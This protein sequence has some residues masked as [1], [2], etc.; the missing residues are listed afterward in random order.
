MQVFSSLFAAHVCNHARCDAR[1]LDA[2]SADGT[3]DWRCSTLLVTNLPVSMTYEQFAIPWSPDSDEHPYKG[4]VLPSGLQ[5]VTFKCLES[6]VWFA[7]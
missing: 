4:G 5:S 7:K 1:I 2:C 6:A 3:R